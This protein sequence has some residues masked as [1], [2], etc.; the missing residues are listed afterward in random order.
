MSF[1]ASAGQRFDRDEPVSTY[2]ATE[3][4]LKAVDSQFTHEVKVNPQ[5]L[6]DRDDPVSS[7]HATE[8]RLAAFEG[9]PTYEVKVNPHSFYREDD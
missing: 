7:Y 9:E 6:A 4:R 1:G 5:L 2:Q 3:L 8:L